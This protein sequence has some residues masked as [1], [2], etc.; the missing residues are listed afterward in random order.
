[1]TPLS[2]IFEYFLFLLAWIVMSEGLV[3][4]KFQSRIIISEKRLLAPRSKIGLVRNGFGPK[5]GSRNGSV[6]ISGFTSTNGGNVS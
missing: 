1:M 4:S 3:F 6:F 5:S 2:T